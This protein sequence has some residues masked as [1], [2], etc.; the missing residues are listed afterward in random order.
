MTV[1]AATTYVE[2][3]GSY[4]LGMAVGAATTTVEQ[5]GHTS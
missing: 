1:G 3:L 2:Q 4:F 5:L